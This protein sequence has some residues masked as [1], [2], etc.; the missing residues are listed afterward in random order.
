MID[1]LSPRGRQCPDGNLRGKNTE[2]GR[3]P[4]ECRQYP[5]LFLGEVRL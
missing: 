4:L 1:L 5:D 2:A 3:L